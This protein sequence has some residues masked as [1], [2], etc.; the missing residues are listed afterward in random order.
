MSTLRHACPRGLVRLMAL[1]VLI[2]TCGPGC[3]GGPPPLPEPTKVSAPAAS[4]P[5]AKVKVKKG[6]SKYPEEDSSFHLRRA[7]GKKSE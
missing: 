1:A 3:G 2:S 7:K 5:G 6:V 4:Q